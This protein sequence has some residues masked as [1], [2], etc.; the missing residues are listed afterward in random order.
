MYF[1][2]LL[3]N[4]V[5]RQEKSIMKKRSLSQKL[6]RTYVGWFVLYLVVLLG[7]TLGFM[8]AT[9]RRNIGN[10]QDQLISSINENVQNY[11]EDM[12]A[13]SLE[14][15]NSEAFKTA[16]IKELPAAYE[17]GRGISESFSTLYQVGYHMI[18]KGYNIGIVVQ[19][20]YYIWMGQNYYI[21]EVDGN[22][23][24][25]YDSL[26]RDETPT[27]KF[28]PENEYLKQ[29]LPEE[30]A[31]ESY[32]TLSRSMSLNKPFLNGKEVLEIQIEAQDFAN[33]IAEMMGSR[34]EG[35]VQINIF[36]TEGTMLYG[37]SSMDLSSYVNADTETTFRDKGSY[38]MV[39]KI[40][41]D[42]LTVV[43][44]MDIGDS[45]QKLYQF[46]II[47]LLLF[48]GFIG[49]ILWK[50]YRTSEATSRPI[51]EICDH[52]R[53]I[54]L[55]EGTGYEEVETD[56][57]EIEFLSHSL[58]EMSDNLEDSL[59]QIITLKDY[60]VHAKMLALQAQ[61]HPHF[62]F[63]TLMMI[64][65]LAEEQ[66]NDNIYR[67]CMNL[68]SMFRYISADA[69]DGVHIYEEIRYVENYVEIMKERFPESR[70]DIDIPLEIM[71][72]RIPKLTIQPLVENAYKYCDRQKPE[73]I[74]KGEAEEGG[75]WTISV[76]DNGKGF[77]PDEKAKIMNKC[78]EGIKNEKILSGQIDGM[79]LVNVYVRLKLFFGE[80]MIYFIEENKGRIIIGRMSDSDDR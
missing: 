76:T 36:D 37:E 16:A 73:I 78:R 22:S 31:G 72:R 13:F 46:W 62:L 49:I 71:D 67:I 61:M 34:E 54:N 3:K 53:R 24:H 9:I 21:R 60:E 5:C 43:Y 39:E 2:K 20:Q 59:N 15:M 8:S 33:D 77:S 28:L 7:I 63:N 44:T 80:G 42:R 52:V 11:F 75:T 41:D 29:V 32:I 27:V 40:F 58:K 65:S 30:A 74:I 10:T 51:R 6:F 19:N 57:D 79:G 55:Q 17:A 26:V 25:T 18:Q 47:A 50:A 66:G 48:F 12:N 38:I 64:A 4:G 68:T 14:L 45:F 1:Q 56:I 35:V 70:V 69:G 23:I